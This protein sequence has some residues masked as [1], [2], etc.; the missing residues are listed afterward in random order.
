MSVVS[1]SG[2]VLGVAVLVLVLSVMNGFERE[3]RLRVLGVLPHGVIYR[4]Q[5]F[6]N[7]QEAAATFM[8]HK[9]VIAAAPYAEGSGLVVADDTVLGVSF[10]GIEPG[11][12]RAVSIIHDFMVEG[13]LSSLTPGSFNVAI[14]VPLARLLGV[15]VGDRLTLVLPDVQLTMAGPLPRTRR[16]E[17]VALFQVGADADKSQLLMHLEDANK[18]RKVQGVDGIRLKLADLFDAPEVIT[19]LTRLSASFDFYGTSWMQSHGNLYGAIQVQKSTMFLLLLML[20]AVAAFN[21]VSNLVMTVDDKRSD[22]AILRTLGASP[23]SILS[24]FIIHGALVGAVGVTI[25]LGVGVAAASYLT[26]IYQSIDSVFSLGLMDEY[27]IHYLPS[28]VLVTDVVTVAIVSFVICLA[29]T[30]Y[31]ALKAANS[32][33]VEALQYDA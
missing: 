17:V 33:P 8:T 5:A 19:T 13:T 11:Y 32:H 12:E 30:L 25:G 2:L 18:L 23:R 20:V 6:E 15:A 10:Y 28:E 14:G 21:V 29:A 26:E 24:I 31:P 7:W 27:F 3:L 4:E 22:I 9:S 16:F 1:I